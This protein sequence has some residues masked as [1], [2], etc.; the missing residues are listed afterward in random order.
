MDTEEMYRRVFEN[1]A[2]WVARRT[3]DDP[4]FFEKMARE[5]VPDFLYIGCSDSR[6]PASE[7]M[8]LEPGEVFIHRNIGNLV[9][10][11][12]LNVNCVI[13][14]GVEVLR[15]KH[16]IVCGHYGCGGVKAA[17][18]PYDRGLLNGWLRQIRD[19]YR[20]HQAELDAID[21]PEARY[22]RLVELNVHEQCDNVIKTAAV[23][24]SWLANGYPI[25]HGWVYDLHNGLL[26]DLGVPFAARLEKVRELYRL[27]VP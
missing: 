10:S 27:V 19:V 11:I 17:M 15:V 8:G 21:D 6:V 9:S 22:R 25:V 7:I 24:K 3:R 2:R 1:N 5:Q 16:I 26:Q 18:E 23:Q 12:D 13:Q 4:E 14:Y 20:L